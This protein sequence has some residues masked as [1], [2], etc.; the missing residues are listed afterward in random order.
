MLNL[1]FFSAESSQLTYVTFVQNQFLDRHAL[2]AQ[3][4]ESDAETR[5]I[6]VLAANVQTLVAAPQ[7]SAGVDVH[8][9]SGTSEP[10]S[11][12]HVAAHYVQGHAQ[13]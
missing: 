13:E 11:G 9:F 1:I 6:R 12:W 10:R 2:V 8:C 5:Q 4:R 3:I 7:T